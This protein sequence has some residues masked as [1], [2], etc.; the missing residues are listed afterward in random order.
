MT[1]RIDVVVVDVAVGVDVVVVV[2]VGVD[3]VVGVVGVGVGVD[4][5]V[6]VGVDVVVGVGVIF[7]CDFFNSR[8][9]ESKKMVESQFRD[10]SLARKVFTINL[11]FMSHLQKT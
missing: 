10:L 6:G 3:V 2:V 8:R 7:S 1:D 5:V 11:T 9:T 4:V